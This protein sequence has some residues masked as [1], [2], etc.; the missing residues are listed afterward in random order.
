MD[1][2][3]PEWRLKLPLTPLVPVSAQKRWESL[4]SECR[5]ER[6]KSKFRETTTA[7]SRGNL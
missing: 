3:G 4:P 6:A 2:L 7:K 1:S 5:R